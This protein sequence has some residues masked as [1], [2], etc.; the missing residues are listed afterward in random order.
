MCKLLV[1]QFSNP[2]IEI[3]EEEQF[4]ILIFGSALYGY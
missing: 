4:T 3:N 1:N 2:K